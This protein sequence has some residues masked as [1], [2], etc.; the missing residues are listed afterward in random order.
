MNTINLINGDCLEEMKQIPDKSVDLILCDLPFGCLSPN[1]GI[2]IRTEPGRVGT[3]KNIPGCPWD[4]KIDLSL[5]WEQVRRIRRS[6]SSPTIHFTTVKYG[7]DLYASNPS[8]FR[9]DLVW[10]KQHG[11]SFLSANKM[12]MRSHEMMFVFSKEGAY[13]TRIDTIDNNRL[14]CPLSVVD[15]RK[16]A[17]PGDHPTSKPTDLYR[18]LIDRYCPEG[19]TVLDPTFGSGNSVFT[20]IELGRNAIGIEKDPTFFNKAFDKLNNL[21]P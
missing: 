18:W 2:V 19:G 7:F 13:Y 17:S 15:V 1:T 21:Y 12:P 6:D 4:I 8:E 20:A 3:K 10:N 11:V 5:F 16:K 9:Y 14:R